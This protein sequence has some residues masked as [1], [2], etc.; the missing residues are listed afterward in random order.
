M[1]AE[2]DS[3]KPTTLDKEISVERTKAMSVEKHHIRTK[4][5][6]KSTS[7]QRRI[8]RCRSNGQKLYEPRKAA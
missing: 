2:K 3:K 7:L 1:Y 5:Q 6:K 4:R 8:R